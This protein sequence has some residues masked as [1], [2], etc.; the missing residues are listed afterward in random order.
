MKPKIIHK[1]NQKFNYDKIADYIYI[2]NNK[3]C[4]THFKKLLLDKKIKADISLEIEEI[5]SPRGVDYYLWIP[6]IDHFAPNQKQLMAGV[7]FL[8]FLVK[9]KI[10]TYIHCRNGHGRA[11]TLVAAYFIMKGKDIDES[12]SFIKKK[13]KTIHLSKEQVLGLKK[14]KRSI[15]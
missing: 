4:H 14:F 2:G 9:N 10:K 5:D 13:R 12:I 1:N 3:C 11:P 6:T 15:K 8:D 7:V